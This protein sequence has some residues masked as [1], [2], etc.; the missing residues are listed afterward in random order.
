MIKIVSL[1]FHSVLSH[2]LLFIFTASLNLRYLWSFL[3]FIYEETKQGEKC[4]PENDCAHLCSYL[5]AFWGW[6]YLRNVLQVLDSNSNL[7]TCKAASFALA[8]HKISLY[9]WASQMVLVVKNIPLTMHETW[10]QIP[11][12]ERSPGGAHGDP[13]WYSCQENAMDRGVWWV[14]VHRVSKQHNWSD[15]A[16]T[17]PFIYNCLVTKLISRQRLVED[18]RFW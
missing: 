16:H 12:S 7:D 13:L 11:V 6:M 5:G 3:C 9:I 14:T 4:T 17:H 10:I 1:F 15:L 18:F 2:V 8:S